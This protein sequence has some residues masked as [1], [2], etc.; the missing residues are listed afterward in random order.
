MTGSGLFINSIS[1]KILT[2]SITDI[3]DFFNMNRGSEWRIWDLHFHTPASYDYKNKSVTN[4][5]IVNGLVSNGVSVVA[6]TDHDIID[7][8]IITEK[9]RNAQRSSCTAWNRVLLRTWWF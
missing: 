8:Q 4:E 3:H 1:S 6:V 7:V 5:E 9:S 2:R